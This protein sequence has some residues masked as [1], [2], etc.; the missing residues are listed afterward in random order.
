MARGNERGDG[1]RAI[2]A[3]GAKRA[4]FSLGSVPGLLKGLIRVI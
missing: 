2:R 4:I 3:S 1:S